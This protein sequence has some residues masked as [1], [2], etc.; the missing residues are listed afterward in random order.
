M[1]KYFKLRRDK[2][3]SGGDRLVEDKENIWQKYERGKDHHYSCQMY[4]QIDKFHHFFSGDQWYGLNISKDRNLPVLN[5][6]KPVGKYKISMI[7]QN[8]LSVVYSSMGGNSSDVVSALNVLAENIWE[9]SKMDVLIWECIKNAYIAGDHY[10]Y[11]HDDRDQFEGSVRA[12][13]FPSLKCRLVNATSIYFADE[14]NS[15]LQEQEYIIISERIPVSKI[16]QEA[17]KNRLSESEIALIK[18]DDDVETH[19]GE[20]IKDQVKTD[21]GKCT[22][23]LYMTKKEGTV[24]FARCCKDV[25]YKPL[26][27]LEGL[28]FY[29]IASLRWETFPGTARGISGVK[30]MIPNQIAINKDLAWIGTV[31]QSSAFPKQVAV[32]DSVSNP[33]ALNVVGSTIKLKSGTVDDVRKAIGYINPA[34]I[35]SDALR[36]YLDILN[37]TRDLEGAGDAALGSVDPTKASGEAI[38][39]VRDQAAISL[40]EQMA[41]FKQF[42]EDNAIIWLKLIKAGSVNGLGVFKDGELLTFS[43]KEIKDAEINVKIDVTPVDPY[44]KTAREL[45]LKELFKGGVIDF[46]EYVYS[47]SDNSSM[48][49]DKLKKIIDERKKG[50]DER[51]LL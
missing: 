33:E 5:I 8:N 45:L 41:L 13:I 48:P 32:E 27:A 6:I 46:S 28:D 20:S 11:W 17:R 10:A 1:E 36:Y 35:S 15:N 42:I 40:N 49:K 21:E 2:R 50:E 9:K 18:S 24:Y 31:L 4:S 51:E 44:S 23:L 30:Q 34:P 14:Q 37:I 26:T 22:S 38:K 16:K 43:E 25:V 39:A 29:P 19:L 3:K 47:L 7:A 12:N